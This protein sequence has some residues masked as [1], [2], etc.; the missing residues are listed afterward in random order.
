MN[1][2]RHAHCFARSF[3]SLSAGLLLPW[4][5]ATVCGLP[6]EEAVWQNLLLFA[7]V[8]LGVAALLPSSFSSSSSSSMLRAH[9]QLFRRVVGGTCLFFITAVLMGAPLVS[10]ANQ[11]LL[12]SLLMSA[13]AAVPL[14]EVG[15]PDGSSEAADRRRGRWQDPTKVAAT[16]GA[17]GAILGAW[18]GACAIP[19]DWD[20][21][22]QPFPISTTY[23]ALAGHAI[24][25][26]L[27]LVFLVYS[28][29]LPHSTPR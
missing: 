29:L 27:A 5:G 9:Q 8:H 10:N 16:L 19:L 20:R 26:A 23:S 7:I 14:A 12:W 22:W 4:L 6:L 11:T 21:P 18:V 2:R 13:L 24:G 1:H 15:L 25:H 3:V 28:F 17:L